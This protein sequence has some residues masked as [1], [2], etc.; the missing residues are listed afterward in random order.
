MS[1]KTQQEKHM[2]KALMYSDLFEKKFLMKQEGDAEK[3]LAS[4]IKKFRRD[5]NKSNNTIICPMDQIIA[6]IPHFT[7]KI[8]DYITSDYGKNSYTNRFVALQGDIVRAATFE[9]LYDL[10]RPGDTVIVLNY[11]GEYGKMYVGFFVVI[12]HKE[13]KFTSITEDISLLMNWS[14]KSIT[15]DPLRGVTVIP[16]SVYGGRPGDDEV[17]KIAD[18]LFGSE[19][20]LKCSFSAI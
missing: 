3:D 4:Q 20:A 11:G 18:R 10:L 5:Y 16:I 8:P 6:A 1:I 13:M 14:T 15:R 19:N 17:G 9:N 2:T 12:D 7:P